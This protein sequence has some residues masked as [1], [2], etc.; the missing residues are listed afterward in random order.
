[1]GDVR[2]IQI[3]RLIRQLQALPSYQELVQEQFHGKIFILIELT[4]TGGKLVNVKKTESCDLAELSPDY[5]LTQS[6]SAETK[7]HLTSSRK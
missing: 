4:L 1:M 5:D 6:R 3:T 7:K 2:E